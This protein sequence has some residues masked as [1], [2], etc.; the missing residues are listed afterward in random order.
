M[1]GHPR[2]SRKR[3]PG[4]NPAYRATPRH[5]TA[6]NAEIASETSSETTGQIRVQDS[7]RTQLGRPGVTGS[8][9]CD[10]VRPVNRRL[11]ER[12]KLVGALTRRADLAAANGA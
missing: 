2:G 4:Q 3:S 1:D 8:P 9:Y 12:A 10:R 5:Q 7:A 11:V 6:R